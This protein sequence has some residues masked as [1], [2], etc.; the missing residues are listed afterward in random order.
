VRRYLYVAT[1]IL[2]PVAVVV[3]W[4]VV[5]S[6]S[7]HPFWPPL[8]E[9]W[10]SFRQEWLGGPRLQADLLPSLLRMTFGFLISVVL[11]IAIGTTIGLSPKVRQYVDP[12]L[13]FLRAIP[14]PALIPVAL[15]FFGLADT[16]K[17][18]LIVLGAIW[19][20]VLSTED[21]VR[22]VEPTLKDVSAVYRLSPQKRLRTVVLPSAGP[23]IFAGV[24]TCLAISLLL[25]V[26]SE[27]VAATN[28][29]GHFIIQSQRTLDIT[30]MWSGMLVLGLL[31]YA[32]TAAFL[33]LQRRVLKWHP[34]FRK[35][36]SQQ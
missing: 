7:Q 16:G 20:V 8:A 27:M 30:S 9:I 33:L 13:Q 4:W 29:L 10:A 31:G 21:G 24:R 32:L 3:A 14:P 19:P 22:S 18:F 25:M 6:N 17:V 1:E 35:G 28:G 5:S 11:G 34:D 2:V 12:V 23:H 15:L 26:I 36:G